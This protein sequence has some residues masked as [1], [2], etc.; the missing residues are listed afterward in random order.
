MCQKSIQDYLIQAFGV[1][2]DFC[3]SKFFQ[4]KMNISNLRIKYKKNNK[5]QLLTQRAPFFHQLTIVSEDEFY[6]LEE[7]GTKTR[8]MHFLEEKKN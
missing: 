7:K 6:R 4:V 2:L 1:E 3:I 5:I 8:Q